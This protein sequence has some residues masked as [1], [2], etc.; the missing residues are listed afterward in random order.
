MTAG[1][2]EQILGPE[3]KRDAVPLDSLGTDRSS[4]SN[5]LPPNYL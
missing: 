3:S 1:M 4:N 2:A 5:R